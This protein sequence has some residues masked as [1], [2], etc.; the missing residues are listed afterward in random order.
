MVKYLVQNLHKNELEDMNQ[1]LN[2]DFLKSFGM[3]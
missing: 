3:M 2:I 1:I